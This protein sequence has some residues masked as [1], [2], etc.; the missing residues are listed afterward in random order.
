MRRAAVALRPRHRLDEGR[1][2]RGVRGVEPGLAQRRHRRRATAVAT[3][4]ST[5]V[6]ACSTKS[7][8]CAQCASRAPG[9]SSV[10]IRISV[11]ASQRREVV[12]VEELRLV[13]ACSEAAARVAREC[14]M[15]APRPRAARGRETPPRPATPRRPSTS[16]S[17]LRRVRSTAKM[18]LSRGVLS[19]T[20]ENG[21]CVGMTKMRND[22]LTIGVASILGPRARRGVRALPQQAPA[23]PQI[24]LG[25]ACAKC[26]TIA[27]CRSSR[28]RRR[29]PTASRRSSTARI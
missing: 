9:V 16:R 24:T 7:M 13:V 18:L 8:K 17:H 27:P 29:C 11:N 25:P 23:Q 10:G 28:R 2:A 15:R 3:S 4:A 21:E 12:R 6:D 22:K 20:I 19:M 1:A 14:W 5:S 26:P